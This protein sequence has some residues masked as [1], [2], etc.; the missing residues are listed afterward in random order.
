M[1]II[2]TAKNI[3]LVILP[4]FL[5]MTCAPL[6]YEDQTRAEGPLSEG[7][8]HY[9]RGVLFA[10][11]GEIDRAVEE[12][13]NAL[14]VDPESSYLM[15]ELAA[16]YI[17]RKEMDRAVTLL[18]RSITYAPEYVDSLILL[19]GLYGNLKRYEDAIHAYKKVIGI[20][21]EK[22]EA[23]LFL[24]L[25]YRENKE[26]EK[27]V[28]ILDDLLKT[29]PSS[30]MGS[31]YLAKTYAAMDRYDEAQMWL[32]KSLN[33]KPTFRPALMDLGM[34]YRSQ[35]KND[36]A[37]AIYGDFIRSNPADVQVRF[38]L[39]NTLMKSKRYGRASEEFEEILEWDN[40]L[41]DARFS[42]GLA[43][44]LGSKDYDRA[45]T[46]FLEVLRVRPGNDKAIYFLASA[47][48]KKGQYADA[49]KELAFI[50]EKSD[51]YVAAR[52]RMGF[53]LKVAGDTEKAIE[54]I[55]GEIERGSEDLEFY[56]FLAALY[57]EEGRL[58]DAEDVLKKALSLLPQDVDLHYRLGVVYGKGNKHRESVEEMEALLTID[59]DNAD[60]INFIGYSYAERGV[61]L[62]EAEAL[63]KKALRLKPDNGYIMDSLGWVYFR[64]NR[65][66]E[67]ISYL[68]KAVDLLPE[69][70]TIAGHLG[71][72]YKKSGQIEKALDVYKQ[73]LH[74][75]PENKE[76]KEKIRSIRLPGE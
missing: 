18:E 12:Y 64:Q 48:E 22:R 13:E 24:S 31:Y 34:L 69:D 56:R 14:G 1:K 9:S 70:P 74:H 30:L 43:Y 23:Y 47:Y 21:P 67:A 65:I 66:E 76:L 62:D 42:L 10:I 45:I 58:G 46:Q 26:Y 38:E 29:D 28:G 5:I 39:G 49:L 61:R 25:F 27:A 6:P 55:R 11:D 59:P 54:L 7:Y 35:D 15:T 36:E 63:I 8:Y 37:I 52:V 32:Q 33:I 50:P 20:D 72:A 44:F 4:L 75:N 41:T 68:Q 16:L 2:Y 57:E 40:S 71:D 3:F 60:A 51:L 53:I 73:A 19:G 17:K